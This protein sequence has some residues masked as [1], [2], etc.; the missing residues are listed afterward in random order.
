M[1]S[2]GSGSPSAKRPK[3]DDG[4]AEAPW[5]RAMGM[6]ALGALYIPLATYAG[7]PI[8]LFLLL[9]AVML[10]EGLKPSPRMLA[11]TVGGAAVFWFL[12]TYVLGVRQPEGVLF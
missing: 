6:L 1:G 2:C 9:A 8:A 10:Y 4:E 3:D 12:F 11:V 7:Y 5:P